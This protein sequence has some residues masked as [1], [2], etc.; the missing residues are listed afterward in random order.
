MRADPEGTIVSNLDPSAAG[1]ADRLPRE[2]NVRCPTCR[3]S[4]SWHNNRQ[5]P[6]CSLRCRL[7]DLSIWLDE[8]YAVRGET[9]DDAR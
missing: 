3:A 2:R 8:G 4:V 5:R 6:F 7:V 9:L 1:Q